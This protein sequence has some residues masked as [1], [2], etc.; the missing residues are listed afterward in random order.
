LKTD[1]DEGTG[2][3]YHVYPVAQPPADLVAAEALGRAAVDLRLAQRTVGDQQDE[4]TS[5][6]G[7]P[8]RSNDMALSELAAQRAILSRGFGF[9]AP[10]VG[11][12]S[13]PY[14]A[15]FDATQGLRNFATP[16]GAPEALR[17]PTAVRSLIAARALGF[18]AAGDELVTLY[19]QPLIQ[20]K[21]R[22]VE[23]VRDDSFQAN[24]VLEYVSRADVD[25]S[26][27]SGEP[28]NRVGA[29]GY[30]NFRNISRFDATGLVQNATTGAGMLLNLTSEHI[31]WATQLLAT[32][33][34]AD[35]V[36]APE[37]V[38]LNGQN[39]EFVSGQKVPFEL[40]QN[41][42]QGT[43]NNIQQFF[44][45]NVGTYVSVTPKIVNWG[46]HGD[47]TAQIL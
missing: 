8:R 16:L 20:I 19:H 6:G 5:D 1:P 22:V 38:T 13:T 7:E 39:V 33:L 12:F 41:V 36:T 30:E 25:Q 46:F 29:Q 28:A 32:E 35:V 21:V 10:F 3:S 34:N 9:G 27:T 23:V 14:P 42:I 17:D 11:P 37:V 4:D 45:K 26:L 2:F 44:Y 47:A 15:P 43:N 31:N 24:S 40:G 18:S